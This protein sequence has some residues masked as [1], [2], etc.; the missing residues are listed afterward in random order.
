MS[1]ERIPAELRELDQWVLWRAEAR[2]GKHTKVPYRVRESF[3]R[4]SSTDPTTWASFEQA[5]A[6]AHLADGIGFVFTEADPFCGVDLDLEL[7]EAERAAIALQLAS[8][9]EWSV[10]GQGWHVVIRASLNGRGRHPAGIGIFDRGRFFVFTGQHVT[11]TP[12]TIEERQAELEAVLAEYLPREEPTREPRPAQPVDLG[13]RELLERAFAARDGDTFRRLWEGDWSSYPSRSEADFALLARLAFWT[14]KDAGRMERLFQGSGLYRAEGPRQPKG[15]GY[16]RRSVERAVAVTADVFEGGQSSSR[17]DRDAIG[18]R[19]VSPSSEKGET[20]IASPRPDVVGTRDGTRS[21]SDVPVGLELRFVDAATFSKK[22]EAG[23]GALVGGDG[24]V[25]VPE[26]GDVMFYG[27]G[28]AG[29]TTLMIDLGLHL[30]AGDDWLGIPVGRPVTV[31]VIENEGPR[32]LFRAKL[33][34]KLDGWNGSDLGGRLLLLEEPWS[35]VSLDDLRIRN[36][37]AAKITELEIDVLIVGPVTRSGMNEAGTLQQVRD[38]TNLIADVREA[39]GRRVTFLLAHHENRGGQVSGAWEGAVD[40][41]LHVQ[42]QG[43][44]QTRVFVQKARWSPGHHKQ[45]LQLRW[46]EGESFEVMEAEERDDNTIA[47][48]I[49]AYVRAHAGTGWTK[50]DKAV[51]GRDGRKRTIRDHLLEGGR[52]VNRG[53]EARMKLWHADDPALMDEDDES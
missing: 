28:G 26:G 7:P 6:T 22:R 44:G 42:A 35:K 46:A 18:T 52:L 10:S 45:K 23:A 19:T 51:S 31:G 2:D 50:V 43:N 48:E 27:D 3:V 47:D 5:I 39:S 29:K 9:T 33:R 34:R 14:G 13:D 37:L 40:T 24:N 8:Y 4:A 25:F 53:S 12:E 20:A 36:A 16:L 1:F 32:P 15:A 38:Y 21:F 30:A 49:L 17:P 11:G 41:L